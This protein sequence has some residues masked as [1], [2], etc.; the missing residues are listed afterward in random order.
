VN[1]TTSTTSTP[2]AMQVHEMM[3]IHLLLWAESGLE[4][5][6]LSG[7]TSETL[8]TLGREIELEEDS[9]LERSPARSLD[10]S[11]ETAEEDDGFAGL[12]ETAEEDGLE[13]GAEV[14]AEEG[15]ALDEGGTPGM[16]DVSGSFVVC[17][18][19]FPFGDVAAPRTNTLRE[20]VKS[21]IANI[22]KMDSTFL[23]LLIYN[24]PSDSR[25]RVFSHD[26][27]RI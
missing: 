6:E 17:D 11:L 25:M 21:S 3:P 23:S 19:E 2:S 27:P 10:S 13:G 20:L 24:P 5:A 9:S 7:S 1:T 12:L 18:V 26:F 14:A 15:F 16:V 4:A 8:P 22:I